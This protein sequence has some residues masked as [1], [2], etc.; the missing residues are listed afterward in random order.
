MKT[1]RIDFQCEIPWICENPMSFLMMRMA[2]SSGFNVNIY[3][4]FADRQRN[5][6]VSLQ[7]LYIFLAGKNAYILHMTNLD[8][9]I[10]LPNLKRYREV[11]RSLFT[12][13][14]YCFV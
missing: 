13:M 7:I 5:N 11:F 1:R 2:R 10:V 8:F 12:S 4:P 9:C 6:S 3:K 14:S